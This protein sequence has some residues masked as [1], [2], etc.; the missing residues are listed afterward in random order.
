MKS[1]RI[2]LNWFVASFCLLILSGIAVKSATA[3]DYVEGISEITDSTTATDLYTYS[4]T[5]LTYNLLAYYSPYIHAYLYQNGSLLADASTGPDADAQDAELDGHA[6]IT[7]GDTYEIAADHY[8]V[9]VYTEVDNG[10]TYYENP[11][12]FVEGSTTDGP[13]GTDYGP[14]DGPV[15]IEVET[16]Y[17]GS[18]AVEITAAK[19]SISSINPASGTIGTSGTTTVSGEYLLDVFTGGTTPSITGSGVT[20]SVG[21]SPTDTKVSLNYSIASNA[22]T[23]N[24]TLTLATRFGTSNGVN[25]LVGDPPARITSITPT[26][27]TAGQTNLKV[28][29]QGTG[30]GTQPSLTITG[31]GVTGSSITS[32]SNTQI[33][34]TVSIAQDAP[35]GSA[36]V[37]VQPGYAGSGF[38]C[39][40]QGQPPNGTDTVAIQAVTPTP[41]IM[42][43]GNNIS[44]NNNVMVLAGQQ[45]A[46][47]VPTPSGYTISTRSYSL[48]SQS[49]V[50]GYTASTSGGN[51]AAIPALNQDSLTFYWINPGTKETITYEYTLS[52]HQKATATATFNIDGPAPLSAGAPFFSATPNQVNVWPPG[53][54]AAGR[55]VNPWLEFGNAYTEN[56][57]D[58]RVNA[59]TPTRNAG[60]FQW[61]QL[62]NSATRQYRANPSIPNSTDGAGL[63][64]YY[65]YP[66]I[67]GSPNVTNDSPGMELL[68]TFGEGAESF[69]ATMYLMWDPALPSGCSPATTVGDPETGAV[70]MTP[71]H[72]T[73]SIPIPIG[74]VT[75]GFSGNG[76][77]TLKSQTST[78][79]TWIL[80]CGAPKPAAPTV[81]TSTQFPQWTTTIHNH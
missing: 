80:N 35:D 45:I 57:M 78:N 74:N 14:G 37:L 43:N 63:D 25:F 1:R 2:V 5:Y 39:N 21:A 67:S 30:F 60:M 22:T 31:A 75:W 71:S 49:A 38:T 73:G 76:L 17:L 70:T 7:L 18:T 69:S 34:A 55:A 58:F 48:N 61:V 3:Q 29:I 27:W 44:G 51:V 72:C 36:S 32:S 19:P 13:T 65:P 42:F 56:G 20:L 59:T 68:S 28:T 26:T 4:D 11:D 15:L 81:Q 12:G 77:N 10:T 66:I 23:G 24:Q 54:G 9:A 47:S 79:T 64:N 33:S 40:C 8:V 52:N 50:G 62:M 16:I 53:V 46:L 6:A 41:Q